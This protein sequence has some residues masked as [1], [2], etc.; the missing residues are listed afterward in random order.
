MAEEAS[1]SA[2]A[3]PAE[4]TSPETWSEA[5]TLELQVAFMKAKIMPPMG[6]VFQA[7][8]AEAY[9]DFSCAT[10]HGPDKKPPTEYL[11][12]LTL[13]DGKITSFEEAPEV[14]KFMA[15]EVVPKM[16]AAMG[17]APYNPETHEGFGCGGCHAIKQE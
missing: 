15:E 4:V 16:A 1:P 13:K 5:T 12:E 14:S 3:A 9:A 6:P 8:D 10:C 2:E 7:S 17:L 11:P